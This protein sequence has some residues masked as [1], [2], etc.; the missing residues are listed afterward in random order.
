MLIQLHQDHADGTSEFIAQSD[1]FG[2]MPQAEFSK[3]LRA[4]IEGVQGRHSLPE[5]SSWHVHNEKSPKFMLAANPK[6][7]EEQTTA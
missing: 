1:D 3:K 7:T 4:W 5:G 6:S 2:D